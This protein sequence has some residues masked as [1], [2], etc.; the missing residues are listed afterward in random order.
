MLI[1]IKSC[2]RWHEF[3]DLAISFRNDQVRLFSRS[4]LTRQHQQRQAAADPLLSSEHRRMNNKPDLRVGVCSRRPRQPPVCLGSSTATMA[5]VNRI[6]KGCWG[7][8]G[9]TKEYLVVSC[10][11]GLPFRIVRGGFCGCV[12]K[13]VCLIRR[14]MVEFF[15]VFVFSALSLDFI[16]QFQQFYW[17]IFL[18][19]LRR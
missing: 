10:V 2:I 9:R 14:F 3:S 11:I 4:T 5:T 18:N 7:L 17:W 8:A 19:L 15:D 12:C 13:V 16:L 6:E 1:I